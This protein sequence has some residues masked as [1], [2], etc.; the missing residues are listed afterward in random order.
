MQALVKQLVQKG[1]LPAPRHLG[2]SSH[3]LPSTIM[4]QIAFGV[5]LRLQEFGSPKWANKSLIITQVEA[6][7]V[8]ERLCFVVCINLGRAL[9]P[10]ISM[11]PSSPKL[12][13]PTAP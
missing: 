8:C 7:L 9:F 4:N 11:G 6:E 3:T 2:R 1:V 10:A 5:G 12:H 13:I